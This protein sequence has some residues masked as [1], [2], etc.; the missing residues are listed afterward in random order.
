MLDPFYTTK[1]GGTGLGLTLSKR[2]IEENEGQVYFESVKGQGTIVH[3][4]FERVN[5]YETN[6]GIG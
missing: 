3:L 6:T 4:Q 5:S 1:K 2:Y